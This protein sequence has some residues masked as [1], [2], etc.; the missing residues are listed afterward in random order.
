LRARGPGAGGFE[1]R[2]E[3]APPPARSRRHRLDPDGEV[4]EERLDF[5]NCFG[6][7]AVRRD[8]D[9]G[10]HGQG[11]H[12]LFALMLGEGF[13]SRVVQRIVRIEKRDHNRR[14]END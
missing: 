9:L 3:D 2:S 6:S 13:H 11:N 12:Q 8:E 14:V 7:S 10:V 5:C 4:R 1:T